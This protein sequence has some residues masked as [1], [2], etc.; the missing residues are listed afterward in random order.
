MSLILLNTVNLTIKQELYNSNTAVYLNIIQNIDDKYK[1]VFI[2]GHHP[3]ITHVCE[4]LSG[5][6]I[7]NIPTC[8][9]VLVK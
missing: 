8:G 1:T 5:I 7:G 6:S 9:I 4:S 2:I 3:T